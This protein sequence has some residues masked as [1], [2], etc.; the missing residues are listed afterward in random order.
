M[1]ESKAR[2]QKENAEGVNLGDQDRDVK[3]AV[4][5]SGRLD[6]MPETSR[7]LRRVEQG[8]INV[9]SSG[10][11][12]LSSQGMSPLM[13][14]HWESCERAVICRFRVANPLLTS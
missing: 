5:N 10:D 14:S 2:E 4:E 9:E 3:N 8:P 13:G 7:A 1:A 12:L 6:E 11:D